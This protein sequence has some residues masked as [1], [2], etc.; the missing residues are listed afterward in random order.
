MT[1]TLTSLYFRSV[2]H[3][4][5]FCSLFVRLFY[6][7]SH[8]CL[9]LLLSLKWSFFAFLPSSPGQSNPSMGR[10]C[11]LLTK[12]FFHQILAFFSFLPIEPQ[13]FVE[14][15]LV[16]NISVL[17]VSSAFCIHLVIKF[18][19]TQQEQKLMMGTCEAFAFLI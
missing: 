6:L 17:R 14:M 1:K 11:W 4:F 9:L 5:V 12:Y 16:K 8:A 10:H 15:S 2:T 18:R 3:G 19:L 7:T 13:L